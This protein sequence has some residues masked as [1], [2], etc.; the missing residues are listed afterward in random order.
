VEL[1]EESARFASNLSVSVGCI[2]CDEQDGLGLVYEEVVPG[3]DPKCPRQTMREHDR[4]HHGAAPPDAADQKPDHGNTNPG[5]GR[6]LEAGPS[7]KVELRL[8]RRTKGRD[9]RDDH[10]SEKAVKIHMS[11]RATLR[12]PAKVVGRFY[13]GVAVEE[14]HS[15]PN[16]RTVAGNR[17][18][19]GPASR[20]AVRRRQD[21]RGV[22]GAVTLGCDD[23][24]SGP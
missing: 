9:R 2:T 12:R 6:A 7:K 17:S 21:P 14:S 19:D 22:Q 11:W 4:E 13:R 15:P 23:P 18:S 1:G 5:T 10:V 20:P 24:K 16:E 8:R 3:R